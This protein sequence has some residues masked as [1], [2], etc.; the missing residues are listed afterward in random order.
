MTY[1][2]LDVLKFLIRDLERTLDWTLDSLGE[3]G[4]AVDAH[5]ELEAI[6]ALGAEAARLCGPLVEAWNRYSDGREVLTTVEIENGHVYSMLWN[7]DPTK[8]VAL[9]HRGKLL[10]DQGEDNG[11]YEIHVTPPQSV[12]VRT[13]PR[14]LRAVKP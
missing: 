1:T 6:E 2:S 9:V 14:A 11:R 8:D 7:P 13:F 4:L 10:A 5:P 3:Q 12:T